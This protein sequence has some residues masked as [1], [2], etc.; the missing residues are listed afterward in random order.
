[1]P[2]CA[3]LQT[4]PRAHMRAHALSH[5]LPHH[6]H[7]HHP[8]FLALVL[9]LALAAIVIVMHETL[10]VICIRPTGVLVV[11]ECSTIAAAAAA[12]ISCGMQIRKH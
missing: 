6:T 4:N 10:M 7:T 1:M 8:P 2:H 3:L 12:L 5:S 9:S 11:T